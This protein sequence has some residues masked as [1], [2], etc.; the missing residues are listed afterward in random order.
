MSDTLNGKQKDEL[1]L[2]IENREIVVDSAKFMRTIDTCA[3]ACNV[4]M[5]WMP[6]LD[7]ILDDILKPNHD[8]PNAFVYLGGKLQMTGMLYNI[9]QRRSNEGTVKELEI[10]TQTANMIDS[11]VRPPFEENNIDL[12]ERCV[13]QA[14]EFGI[15]V[16]KDENLS[17]GGKFSR[18]S[19]KQTDL[20]FNH[21]KDLAWQRG[22][23]L[24]CTEYGELEIILPNVDGQPVG[25]IEEQN[26]LTE[27]YEVT[28]NGRQRFNT[29]E[30]IVS[31]SRKDKTKVK[32]QA[33]DE[34]VP[35]I[36]FL[37]F[38]ADESLPG[39]GLNAALW[40]RNKSAADSLNIQFPVNSWYAPNGTLFKPNTTITVV[41]DAMSL[42]K[43]FTFLISQVEFNYSSGGA[44]AL[45][46]L[47]PPSMY[48]NGEIIEPWSE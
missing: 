44:T 24:S 18:V 23:L 47:K 40:R 10:F 11:T 1:T 20:C 41:S 27:V 35:A 12:Y 19:A 43:G 34:Y 6:G 17:V 4:S 7:P 14:R 32:H 13:N 5:E 46:S 29:Y 28:F 26:P 30:A 9:T 31:S 33:I 3:D 8:Y 22:A 36:R 16:V 38:S 45:L 21:L 25:T 48:T 39:E 37:T 42:E 2:I 15:Q